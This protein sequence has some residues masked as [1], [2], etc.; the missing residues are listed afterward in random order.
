V[1]TFPVIVLALSVLAIAYRYYSRFISDKVMGLDDSR[2]TPAHTKYDGQNYYPMTKWVLFGQH[3]SGIT[4]AGP[5]VGPV[6]AAQFGFLPGLIWLVVGVCLAG[7]VQDFI[8]LFASVRREGKSLADIARTEISGLSGLSATLAILFVVVIATAGLGMTMVNAITGSSWA[9]F[10]IA[11][12]FPIAMIMGLWMYKIRPGKGIRE[13]TIFGIASLFAAVIG[14]K[15]IPDSFLAPYFT[16]SSHGLTIWLAVYALA[17]SVLPVWLLL[18]PRGYLSTFMK[19]G[20]IAALIIGVLVVHP[21]F[22]MPAM[23]QFTAGSGPVI[24]GPMFPFAFITIACG[25]I[26]GFHSLI[27]SGTTPK[28]VS[29][30]SH[31]RPVGYGAMLCEGVVGIMALVAATSMYPGDYFAINSLG[32]RQGTV[33][34]TKVATIKDATGAPTFPV[35]NLDDLS[36]QVGENVDGRTGGAVSLAVGMAQIFTAIPGMRSLMSYWYHFAIMFEAVFILTTIESGTRVGRFITQEFGGRK[37]KFLA[38]SNS[39]TANIIASSVVVFAW[40]YFLWTGNISTIW[41]MFGIANQLLA[42]VALTVGTSMILNMG[43]LKYAWVTFIPMLF[44]SSNTLYGGFLSIR[45]NFWPLTASPNPALQTQGWVDTLC[46][47]TMMFLVLV[48]LFDAFNRWRKII[49]IGMP[50]VE[51]AGD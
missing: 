22:K 42:A 14:G 32:G 15:F 7:A 39:L 41:P 21:T 51:Y 6:L 36:A 28:M 23:T 20:T 47:A 16:Y 33:F 38:N 49:F 45:D 12:T 46:T 2:T 17:A 31:M 5:L 34:Q 26:S 43:K 24:P 4:G 50:Q 30:E 48:I 13:A 29:Q 1:N 44:L 25:A 19:L 8:V 40:A 35:T 18:A 37:I 27:S 10:T 11:M 3:F 9:T